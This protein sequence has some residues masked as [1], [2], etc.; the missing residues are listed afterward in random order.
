MD[1]YLKFNL[2]ETSDG[3]GFRTPFAQTAFFFAHE[4]HPMRAQS[5]RFF[6]TCWAGLL[7]GDFYCFDT[8]PD[9]QMAEFL[10]E[11]DVEPMGTGLVD[12]RYFFQLTI[13]RFTTKFNKADHEGRIQRLWSEKY[14]KPLTVEKALSIQKNLTD[15]YSL[16]WKWHCE[17]VGIQL[18]P[19][20]HNE[21]GSQV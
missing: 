15:F 4:G 13:Y 11:W 1:K 19:G 18:E 9:D 7:A 12:S 3:E 10:P 14:G 5:L 17:R 8:P 16:I 21:V 20:R 2:Y 6:E